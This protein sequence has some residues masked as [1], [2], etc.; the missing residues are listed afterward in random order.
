[1]PADESELEGR[2]LEIAFENSSKPVTLLS[3][4]PGEGIDA[5]NSNRTERWTDLGLDLFGTGS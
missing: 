5:L 1:M 4:Q 2:K 3:D